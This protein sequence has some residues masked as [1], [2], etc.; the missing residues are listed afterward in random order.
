MKNRTLWLVVLVAAV[1]VLAAGA[2]GAMPARP[3]AEGDLAAEINYQGRL[4]D[5]DGHPLD[6]AYAM[7]FQIWSAEVGGTQ[8]WDSGLMT[9]DVDHGLF[10]VVLAVNP[11][12]FNG[13]EL[14]LA[15]QV[16]GEW[17]SPRQELLAVPYALG[18][19]P[20]AEVKGQPDPAG[21]V[22][23]VE[24]A[25]THATRAAVWGYTSTGDAVRGTSAG[26]YGLAGYTDDGYAVYGLDGGTTA[27]KGYAGLFHSANG[28]GLKA[29]TDSNQHY[30]HAG[31]FEANYGYGV[32]AQSD[33]NNAIRAVGGSD[34]DLAGVWQPGGKVG[35]VG[36]SG[37]GRGVYGSSRDWYGVSGYSSNS[38]GVYGS[39][40]S[41]TGAG[42]IGVGPSHNW[43]DFGSAYFMPGG[44][45]YGRNG[46]VGMTQTAAGYGV[47][48]YNRTDPGS[49][50]AGFFKSEKGDGVYII[51]AAG[52]TALAV[53]GGTKNA[54]VSTSEGDR[55]LYTEE[56]T[57]VWF[58][59]YGFGAL[60]DGRAEIV[61]DPLFAQTVNLNEPYHVFLQ[62]YGDGEIYVQDRTA[63]G[64]LVLLGEGDPSVEFSYRIVGRRLGYEDA[65][66]EA[67]STPAGVEGQ[68]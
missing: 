41:T 30:N 58:S 14:W 56:S 20:G 48:G 27:S 67:L 7:K 45:F 53:S 13:Q 38:L 18:L 36:L 31:I 19:R 24:M 52:K 16:E 26:G 2:A 5:A 17:L 11:R 25:G 54:V 43:S 57:E 15:I 55:L 59:D 65:R 68:Q 61:I 28:I 9:V 6:G 4:T 50:Y 8:W 3:D 10:N 29:S 46:V 62:A 22:M 21:Y 66:L 37:S 32:Y 63:S 23:R 42:V 12:N 35:V 39:T 33:Q 60:V 40:N 64:F 44:L 47:L 51:T 34:S 49:G 1:L